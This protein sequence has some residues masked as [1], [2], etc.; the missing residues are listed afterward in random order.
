MILCCKCGTQ[1]EPRNLNMCDFCR[2]TE[3]STTDFKKDDMIECCRSCSRYLYN[4]SWYSAEW[5]SKELLDILLKKVS[6]KYEINDAHFL[7]TEP[8]S[9]RILIK[10]IYTNQNI[11]HPIEIK[12]VIKNKQCTDCQ[13][14]EA[15]QFWNCIVQ[16]RQKVEHKKTFLYLEHILLENNIIGGEI[17]NIKDRKDGVDF[18]FLDRAE[19]VKFFNFVKESVCCRTKTSER[20]ISRD[21]NSNKSNY[22]YSFSIEIVPVCKDDIIFISERLSKF[23]SVDRY[24]LV[25]KVSTRI[26]CLDIKN[27]KVVEFTDKFYWQNEKEICV[28]FSSKSLRKFIVSEVEG[29]SKKAYSKEVEGSDIYSQKLSNQTQLCCYDVYVTTDYT[30][31]VH[32][33]THL[34]LKEGDYVLG[35]DFGHANISNVEECDFQIILVKRFFEKSKNKKTNKFYRNRNAVSFNEESEFSS[36]G[37]NSGEYDEE[38]DILADLTGL[39]M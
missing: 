29:V 28:V 37:K 10:I 21:L 34:Y 24:L 14:I 22:K 11:E 1:I 23:L 20:L 19:A 7:Y 3:M 35:Y 30:T 33:K 25:T 31:S 16:V 39:E 5:H 9:K 8:H 17:T 15:K 12:F 4:K 38:E 32:C 18:Y 13:R 26:F 27:L 2:A 36:H 6:S